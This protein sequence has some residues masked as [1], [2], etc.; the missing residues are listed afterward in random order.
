[1]RN[2]IFAFGGD[3]QVSLSCIE[4]HRSFSFTRNI[5]LFDSGT[6]LAPFAVGQVSA[7]SLEWDHNLY[8]D[9]RGKRLG[10]AGMTWTQWRKLGF[11][12]HSATADPGFQNAGKRRFGLKRSSPAWKIGFQPFDLSR[13]GPRRA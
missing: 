6:L 12:R 8:F 7:A 2:N 4:Q 1:V 13:V 3:A 11:D 10:M 5:V 9:L